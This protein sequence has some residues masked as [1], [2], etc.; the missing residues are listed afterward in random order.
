MSEDVLAIFDDIV[1][2]FLATFKNHAFSQVC[3]TYLWSVRGKMD[4]KDYSRLNTKK[5]AEPNDPR[6]H[7][8]E[9]DGFPTTVSSSERMLR[10]YDENFAEKET[11]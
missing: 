3:A 10:V 7:Q 1:I 2:E 9:G 6:E 4:Y 8:N 11:A 5:P